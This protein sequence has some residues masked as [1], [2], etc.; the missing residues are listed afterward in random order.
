MTQSELK[1]NRKKGTKKKEL[2]AELFPDGY[3]LFDYEGEDPVWSD[4]LIRELPDSW[5]SDVNGKAKLEDYHSYRVPQRIYVNNRGGFS[6]EPTESCPVPAWYVP[7]RLLFDPTSGMVYDSNT[8]E[9]TKL[10]KLGN[11]GRST[12]TTI[13]A[14]GV[15]RELIRQQQPDKIQKLLSFT[16]NR[17]DASL[18]AGHFNDFIVT[19]RLRSALY[20]ALQKESHHKLKVRDLADAVF[21]VLNIKEAEYAR[22]PNDDFPDPDNEDAFKSYLTILLLLDLKKGWRY[23]LP[24]LEQTGLLTISYDR[25]D[26]FC[27]R[28]EFFTGDEILADETPESRVEILTNLLHY[29]RTS[30]AITHPYFEGL[31][32]QTES[33]LQL[34]LDESKFWSPEKN[35]RIPSP[36][37][38]RY[39][40]PGRTTRDFPTESIG[41]QSKFGKYIKQLFSFGFKLKFGCMCFCHCFSIY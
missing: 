30:N 10:M 28:E 5:W 12:A 15:V 32:S 20:H 21:N 16:D 31:R 27:S 6:D 26:E 3:L 17:Q 8:K 41:P 23:N 19:V 36:I 37:F 11:E 40:N 14:F 13:T 2:S 29:F 38:M 35:W 33:Q 7:A 1:P 18:Q 25:L 4:E 22:E 24:N 34:K 9:N 39:K